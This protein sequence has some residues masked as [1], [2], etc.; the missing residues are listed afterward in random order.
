MSLNLRAYKQLKPNV[1]IFAGGTGIR[2]IHIALAKHCTVTR[3]LPVCDNGGSSK[4]IRQRFKLMPVGDIRHALVTAAQSQSSDRDI[5][6]LLN[7]RLP[8]D[9]SAIEL[10]KELAVFCAS[11]HPLMQKFQKE[12]REAIQNYIVQFKK[13]AR[14]LKIAGGSI[15]N[16][17]LV[18]A[19]LVHGHINSAITAVKDLFEINADVW[20]VS[21]VNDLQLRAELEDG[22][23]ILGQEAIT[24]IDR[25]HIPYKIKS[26]DYVDQEKMPAINSV[27][28]DA[29]NKADMIVFGPGSFFTS[30]L[31]HLMVKNSADLI[32]QLSVPKIFI[33]NMLQANECYGY[34]LYELIRYYLAQA[35]KVSNQNHV[36]QAYVNTILANKYP[37]QSTLDKKYLSPGRGLE[38]L[39]KYGISIITK[40]FEDPWN[41]GTHDANLICETLMRVM[42]EYSKDKVNLG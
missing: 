23:E 22:R 35:K 36:N 3:V 6:R 7:W 29:I 14:G 11:R 2:D 10:H 5:I 20:P 12:Q 8:E 25:L 27:V 19:Y 32:A 9:A 33:G 16:F 21:V 39:N 17:I 38:E 37:G 4:A 18:G 42:S 26:V 31:P 34:G 41:P 28:V 13:N 1:V 30:V 40:D 15:G 24:S